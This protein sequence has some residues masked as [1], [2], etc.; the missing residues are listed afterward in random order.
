[1]ICCECTYKV[2]DVQPIG[3]P[4]CGAVGR[5]VDPVRRCISTSGGGQ[6]VVVPIINERVPEN[7]ESPGS[8]GLGGKSS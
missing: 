8:F 5:V 6:I 1:M 7:K 4:A 2:R 3:E